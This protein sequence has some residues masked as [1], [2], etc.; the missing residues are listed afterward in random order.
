MIFD[1]HAHY[2]SERFDGDREELLSEVLGSGVCGIIECATDA[3]TIEA[4]V[5]FAMAHDGVYCALGV[6]PH[7]ADEYSDELEKRIEELIQN[8]KAIAIGEI[9]LDY[10]YDFHPRELQKEVLSRQIRLAKRLGLPVILHSRESTADMMEI[11]ENENADN[12][13]MHCFSGSVETAQQLLD[14]GLYIGV[15]GSLT[16]KGA[17]KGIE[18]VKMLPMERLLLETDAPYLTPVPFR[19]ERNDSRYIRYVADMIAG[20]KGVS[21]QKVTDIACDNAKRLFGIK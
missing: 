18:V 8:E 5:S 14:M 19:G 16:F 13:V 21:A 3:R 9:G 4:S 2:L 1:S 7:S 12:G 11:L 10:H 15:G 6:H 17:V 20:I